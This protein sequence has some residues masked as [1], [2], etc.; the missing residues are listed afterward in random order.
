MRLR[1]NT[2]VE[3]APELEAIATAGAERSRA[4][5]DG[6]PQREA[7]LQR[8][9]REAATRAIA[10]GAPLGAIAEAERI[11]QQ[12]AREELGS[13]VL[14]T[15]ERAAQRKREAENTYEQAVLRAG[16]LGLAHR[17]VAAAAQVAHATVRALLV[18]TQ[19]TMANGGAPT[20]TPASNEASPEQQPADRS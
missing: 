13:E 14:R 7:E 19:T 16:R 9:V 20:T 11:G 18:R 6:D 4:H 1:Q 10:A 3:L 15:V 12:R 5:A 2:D 17:D 8:S